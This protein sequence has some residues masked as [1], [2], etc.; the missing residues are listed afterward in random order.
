[1]NS[2]AHALQELTSDLPVASSIGWTLYDLIEAISEEVLPGKE[3]LV[4]AAVSDLA[5]SGNIK[6]LRSHSQVII[7]SNSI[8]L[9][10]PMS[11]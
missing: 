7:T 10:A 5:K 3:G 6:W 1:M 2:L 11:F 8:P 4:V 9:K